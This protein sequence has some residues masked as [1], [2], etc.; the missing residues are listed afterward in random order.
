M[1][2]FTDWL[3]GPSPLVAAASTVENPS[4]LDAVST[5]GTRS[6]AE[7]WKV[8]RNPSAG[9]IHYATTQQ[10]RLVS[11][12]GWD[13]TIDGTQLD[14]E[15]SQALITATFGTKMNDLTKTGALHLQVA[16]G[17][18]LG[19][20]DNKWHVFPSTANYRTKD[21]MK[22]ADILVSVT[23]PDP[24]DP[25]R[26]DSPVIAC[27]DVA[28]ELI[29][30]RA[31]SRAS[32]R[33][34]TA[35]QGILWYP[36]EGVQDQIKFKRDLTTVITAPLADEMSAASVTPNLVGFA[37]DWIDKIEKMD[38][39]GEYDTKLHVRIEALVKQIGTI[40]DCPP[41]LLLGMGDINHWTAWAV[42]EDNWFGHIEPL[43]TEIGAG[44]AEALARA[45][46]LDPEGVEFTPDPAPLIQRRPSTADVLQAFSLNLVSGEWA[47]AQL[48]ADEDD[49]G[50]PPALEPDDTDVVDAEIV[51]EPSTPVAAAAVKP[52]FDTRRLMAVDRQALDSTIDLAEAALT[53]C[54]ERVGAQMRARVQ[55]DPALKESIRDI[56]NEELPRK[57]G[58][59][60]TALPGLDA[61]ITDT[62]T[63]VLPRRWSKIVTRAYE[64]TRAAGLDVTLDTADLEESTNTLVAALSGVAVPF[65]LGEAT[66]GKV[67]NAAQRAIALA[68]GGDDPSP[69]VV[70]ALGLPSPLGLG[71]AL[72][73]KALLWVAREV[74]LLARSFRWV[75]GSDPRSDPHPMHESLDGQTFDGDAIVED[76][77]R[78]YPGD[79]SGCL[80]GVEPIWEE[81]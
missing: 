13:L 71:I 63:S 6:A 19:R 37:G 77:I 40:L 25:T 1:G 33:N 68:G 56:P 31:Q 21:I 41:Q 70:A 18:Y 28:R 10:G 67:W 50:E 8:W 5:T 48:G 26:P 27:L 79:H 30:A 65:M 34:R 23:T 3:R 35:Q 53:R 9:E 22:R 42:Q 80:C 46:D 11:R 57:M 59:Q 61:T 60:L 29:L 15:D 74:G 17:Y 78:W 64:Q 12:V 14:P 62:L 75:Y 38:L 69:P 73:G 58:E 45:A 76:G 20:V 49:A 44:F 47:R 54:A 4:Q 39:G 32:S 51:E 16:G 66:D 36:L 52:P 43:A 81:V 55:G 72:G 2:R 24:E 7:A